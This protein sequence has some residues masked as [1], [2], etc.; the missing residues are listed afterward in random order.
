MGSKISQAVRAM[1]TFRNPLYLRD[2][3]GHDILEL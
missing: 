3:S 1:M 2:R